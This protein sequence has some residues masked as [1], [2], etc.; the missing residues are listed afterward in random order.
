MKSS[1]SR[2]P[3]RRRPQDRLHG[4]STTRLAVAACCVV[5][6]NACGSSD[7]EVA[8]EQ[9]PTTAAAEASEADVAETEGA[10]ATDPPSVE[11]NTTQDGRRIAVGEIYADSE[12]STIYLGLAEIPVGPDI[13]EGGT[14]YVALFDATYLDPVELGPDAFSPSVAAYLTDGGQAENDQTGVGCDATV[15]AAAGY[16]RLIETRIGKDETVTGYLSPFHVSS[17]TIDDVETVTLYGADPAL[18]GFE[19][20]L[21][22]T[23]TG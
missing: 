18:G 6:A 7:A 13:F 14:C 3:G 21:V 2:A 23:F 4:L 5:L 8:S 11:E 19:P 9:S 16:E 1:F 12:F 15:L 17:G 10:E 22:E 20:T